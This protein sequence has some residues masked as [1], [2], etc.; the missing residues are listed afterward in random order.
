MSEDYSDQLIYS[1]HWIQKE[2]EEFSAY[3]ARCDLQQK[4]FDMLMKRKGFCF[5][6]KFGIDDVRPMWECDIDITELMKIIILPKVAIDCPLCQ[7]YD[8]EVTKERT[9]MTRI[10]DPGYPNGFAD[11]DGVLHKCVCIYKGRKREMLKFKHRRA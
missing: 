3:I 7:P 2:G 9:F 6:I 8:D 10:I 1:R 11:T 4:Q 5:M